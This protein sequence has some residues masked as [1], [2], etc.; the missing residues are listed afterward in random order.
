ML[1]GKGVVMVLKDRF[2]ELV[3]VEGGLVD[4]E[5]FVSE[6]L[7][8]LEQE[9]VFGKSWLFLA[10]E[11]M[12]PKPGD[13][14][15]N[16]MGEDAVIVMRGMDGKVRVFLNK[17]RHRGN[18]VCLFDRGNAKA[19]TCSFHG[20]TYGTEGQLTGV[21][22]YD[23]VYLGQLDRGEMGLVEVPRVESVGGLIFGNW[24]AAAMS[25]DAY[26]GDVKWY[27]ETFL[28]VE[29]LGGIQVVPGKQSYMLP[30]N[31]KLLAENFQGDHYHFA[32]THASVIKLYQMEAQAANGGGTGRRARLRRRGP[33]DPTYEVTAGYLQGAPHGLGSL[34]VGRHTF[35]ND[36]YAAESLGPEAVE[37][38]QHRYNLLRE[39]VQAVKED[40]YSFVRGNMFPNFS[41]I[42]ISSAL[43]GIGLL[44]WHPRSPLR[45]NLWQWGAVEK[46]AP[47][48]V[49]E[50]AIAA[51]MQGQAGAG[52][53]GMDD[54][55]NFE[56][57]SE[58]VRGPRARK[59]PFDYTMSL[60]YEQSYPG[61]EEWDVAG[62][63]GLLG[64]HITEVNQRQFYRYWRELMV[65]K[66]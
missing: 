43:E 66:T 55:E 37:W 53:V 48:I 36:L 21:P 29:W 17:C 42:G 32:S 45:T 22:H 31:W 46:D 24:D 54:G 10:H 41:V 16:Y 6:E 11:S 28:S 49:K 5:I 13:Y 23:E 58:M 47:K 12:V 26:L 57:I 56:R 65:D 35:E 9:R 61:S 64:P 3:D 30:G 59:V 7:Y 19:F 4:N 51:L 39:R 27:L 2:E 15:S 1:R 60:G 52:L 50:T 25:L 62:L 18:R 38:V 33:E 14:I 63:P 20:W 44:V 34:R 8:A 40:A